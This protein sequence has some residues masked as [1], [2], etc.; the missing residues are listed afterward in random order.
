MPPHTVLLIR[1]AEKPDPSRDIRGVDLRGHDD[2]SELSVTGWQRSGA[3]ARLFSPAQ[4]AEMLPRPDVIFAARSH[5]R[6]ARPLRTVQ[7]LSRTLGTPLRDAH[8]SDDIDGLIQDIRECPG[9]AMVCWRHE[10]IASIARAL[11]GA[12][13][14]VPEW[15][16]QRFD[17][18]WVLGLREGRWSFRQ[19]PQLLLPDDS[20]D[21]IR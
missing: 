7:L 4:A 6:S 21:P 3:L 18:V 15:D 2:P 10:D 12:D 5:A 19:R 1:H 17:V 13:W 16:P 8:D 11:L 9:V 14:S 20:R